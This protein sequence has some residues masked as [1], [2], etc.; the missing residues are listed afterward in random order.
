MLDE[1]GEAKNSDIIEVLESSQSQQLEGLILII[2][3]AT[4]NLNG[5][6]FSTEYQFITKLL[7]GEVEAAA[8]LALC[9]EMDDLSEVDD[10]DNWIKAN[11]LFEV[12]SQRTQM[13]EHKVNSL[14][15]YR[16]KDDISGWL[17]KEMNFW[18]QSSKDS[19]VTKEEW[20][21]L[22]ADKEYDIRGRKVYIGLDLSRTDDITAVSWVIP[23]EE[24][25]KF[26]I[27]THGF[28]SS[29]GGID[30]KI[31]N[32]KIPYRQ[33][34]NM[35]LIDISTL[36]TGLVDIQ[37]MVDW[38][39]NFVYEYNLEVIGVYYD[40]VMINTVLSDLNNTFYEK[41]I[42]VPQR[43]NYLSAP[44]RTLREMIRKGDIIHTGNPLLTRAMYNAVLKETNDAIMIDKSM[45]RNKIDP[46]D[47]VIN[48]M[49]DGQFHD[50]N[51]SSAQELYDSGQYGFGV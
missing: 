41:L 30:R 26:L 25:G 3:T 22:K 32:D 48:A 42:E 44:T 2:S 15:E 40:P 33:Y 47:A 1:Y 18:V 11:P 10:E 5:P 39:V 27:D 45:N 8:Y 35:G 37:F 23:I 31:Q 21:V 7:N 28:V 6:M 14:A 38:L 19:Y 17:T 43:I 16:G 20:E 13:T 49:Y 12:E 50:F 51:S 9:W 29:K 46:V 24:E 36:E 4:K 34:E